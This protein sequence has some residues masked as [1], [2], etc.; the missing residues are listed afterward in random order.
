M[1]ARQE[2]RDDLER[3]RTLRDHTTDERAGSAIE[4][5]IPETENRLTQIEN[6]SG[7]RS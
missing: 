6:R 5:L 7:W 3:Y 4:Q 2:L 1:D